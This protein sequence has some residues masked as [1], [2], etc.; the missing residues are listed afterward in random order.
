MIQD[1]VKFVMQEEM[2]VLLMKTAEISYKEAANQI[3]SLLQNISDAVVDV[4]NLRV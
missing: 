3:E 4:R 2:V 1:E